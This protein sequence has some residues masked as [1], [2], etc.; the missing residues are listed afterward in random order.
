MPRRVADLPVAIAVGNEPVI[1]LMAATPMLYTQLEYKVAAVMQGKPYRV[2]KNAKGLDL[3]WGSDYILEGR[4]LSRRR[5]PVRRIPG[6]LF[7]LPQIPGRRDRPRRTVS[8]NHR[9]EACVRRVYRRLG[10]L[11]LA[12]VDE[13]GV[14]VAFEIDVRLITDAPLD[15]RVEPVALARSGPRPASSAIGCTR[16]PFSTNCPRA[17]SPKPSTCCK[18]SGLPQRGTTPRRRS[19]LSSRFMP[20]N[21]RRPP[22][23]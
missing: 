4:I 3:P 23:A 2:V 19:T 6:L 22:N 17:S 16:P 18:R 11:A 1:T 20:S 5:E 15:N 9:G 21:K 8:I 13:R 14:V 7:R 12:H 10:K